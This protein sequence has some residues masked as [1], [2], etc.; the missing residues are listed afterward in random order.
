V[1]R[2]IVPFVPPTLFILVVMALELFTN[3][4]MKSWMCMHPRTGLGLLQ[5][6]THPFVDQNWGVCLVNV[7]FWFLMTYMISFFGMWLPYVLTSLL[8]LFG[9]IFCWI[10]VR[11]APWCGLSGIL[12]GLFFFQIG[13]LLSERPINYQ[14][15]AVWILIVVGYI[16]VTW[17][18]LPGSSEIVCIEGHFYNAV[19]GLILCW[20]HI[21]RGSFA[22]YIHPHTELQEQPDTTQYPPVQGRVTSP[23]RNQFPSPN[24]KVVIEMQDVGEIVPTGSASNIDDVSTRV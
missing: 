24:S 3:G 16:V 9:G 19:I 22:D 14:V 1:K 2:R 15:T 20:M 6:I 4:G 11:D 12:I 7:A 23:T 17:L 18:I 5:I 8:W 10:A 21:S 13:C